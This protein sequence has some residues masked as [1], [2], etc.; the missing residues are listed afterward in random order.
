MKR[1]TLPVITLLITALLFM[2]FS[3]SAGGAHASAAKRK[4][5][6]PAPDFVINAP[7]GHLGF[8]AQGAIP[9]SPCSNCNGGILPEPAYPVDVYG[10]CF[11]DW[12]TMAIVPLNGFLGTVMLTL[13]GLPSGVTS[14]T[15]PTVTVTQKGIPA[16]FTFELQ[17]SSTATL[18]N[19]TV[20]ITGTSVSLVH[21]I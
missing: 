13:S 18:G 7:V 17:A 19:A 4:P 6:L 5:P 21:T 3:F 2:M 1:V 20:T 15:T 14:L 8:L 9:G 12:N 11:Y 10:D 16:L